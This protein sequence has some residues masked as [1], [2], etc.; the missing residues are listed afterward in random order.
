MPTFIITP[1]PDKIPGATHTKADGTRWKIRDVTGKIKGGD[2]SR[3]PTS[4]EGYTEIDPPA[5]VVVV[6]QTV[7]R[8]LF[9]RSLY[10]Q[11]GITAEQV[12]GMIVAEYANDE[13]AKQLA[14]IELDNAAT[15]ERKNPLVAAI[16]AKLGKTTAQVDLVFINAVPVA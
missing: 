12:R 15:V 7:D 8:L 3:L 6:P 13:P 5:P 11:F 4:L 2:A 10:Q 14:L 9:W 16:A 1:V